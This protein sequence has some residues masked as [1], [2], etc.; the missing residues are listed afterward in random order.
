MLDGPAHIKNRL[1]DLL[2]VGKPARKVNKVFS[3]HPLHEKCTSVKINLIFKNTFYMCIVS[4]PGAP[5]L[6]DSSNKYS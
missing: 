1:V 6:E 4:K 3:F 5:L 2:V